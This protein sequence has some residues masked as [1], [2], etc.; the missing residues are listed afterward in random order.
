ML[1]YDNVNDTFR[2]GK[3]ITLGECTIQFEVVINFDIIAYK[4]GVPHLSYGGYIN[5]GR[6]WDKEG[7]Q[8]DPGDPDGEDEHPPIDDPN[9]PYDGPFNYGDVV[10]YDMTKAFSDKFEG[11]LINVN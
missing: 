9:G 8:T 1:I 10:I 5:G 4:D 2:E 7:Y 3:G 11:Q 6:V